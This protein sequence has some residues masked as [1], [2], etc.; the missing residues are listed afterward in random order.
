MATLSVFNFITLNGAFKGAKGDIQ[1]HRHG[2]EEAAYAAQGA[3]SKSVL[4]F[5]RKTYQMMASWW[6]TPMAAQS[7]PDVARG[8]N[9]SSKIVFSRTLKKATW[10]NTRIIGGDP[11]KA[12]RR[13]KKEQEGFLT[14]LGSGSIVTLCAEHGLIDDYKIMVDPVLMG[15]G[16]PLTK[17]LTHQVDLELVAHRVFRSGVVLLQYK[18]KR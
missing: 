4:L 14:I 7:M 5:G 15:S 9:A 3:N 10:E 16:T 12:I 17:S 11:V 8:M 13:M 1:W 2:G 6:P 18:P